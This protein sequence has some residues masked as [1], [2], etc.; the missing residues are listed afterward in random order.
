MYGSGADFIDSLDAGTKRADC[1]LLDAHMPEMTGLELLHQLKD[2]GVHVP[3]FIL[4][5]DDVSNVSRHYVAAGA[6]GCLGKP[7]SSRDI[8][9]AVERALARS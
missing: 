3:T 5:G 7:I 6:V 1:I 2:R 9:S 8:S 4:T